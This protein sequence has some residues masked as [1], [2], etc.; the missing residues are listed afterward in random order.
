MWALFSLSQRP[1]VQSKLRAELLSVPTPTPDMD[2][3]SALPYLD[4]VT[5]ETLRVHAAVPNTI[6]IA[7]RDDCIPLN[8]P[9]VDKHGKVRREINIKKGEGVFIPILAMNRDKSIWGEDAQE[10][11]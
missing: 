10:F 2:T 4:A 3:L 5:R 6:R 7:M 1:D 9:F 8:E 11:K